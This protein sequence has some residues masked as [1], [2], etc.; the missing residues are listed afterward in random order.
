MNLQ[1]ESAL[2][3][4]QI[5]HLALQ[6]T[7]SMWASQERSLETETPEYV[8]E[9]I[10]EML[11]PTTLSSIGGGWQSLEIN[12]NLVF[13]VFKHKPECFTHATTELMSL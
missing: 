10:L 9:G 3:S 6:H 13:W 1:H 8:T 4:S 2:C 12:R 11:V 7:V 5:C